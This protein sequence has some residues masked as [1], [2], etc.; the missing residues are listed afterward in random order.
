M[1]KEGPILVIEDDPDDQ[2]LMARI[3]NKLQYKNE[4]LFFSDGEQALEY[5]DTQDVVPFIILSDIKMP[6]LDG[7]ALRT[8][9]KTHRSVELKSVPY[10]FFSTA[11]TPKLV[12]D[13]YA[14][15]VQ[16]VFIKDSLLPELEKTI[17]AIMEY[18]SRCAAPIPGN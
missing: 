8:A 15:S 6:K 14:M 3:F 16:G 9:L 2:F 4:V 11:L 10:L 5:L 17:S 1:N 13:A 18:W 7:F 12:T